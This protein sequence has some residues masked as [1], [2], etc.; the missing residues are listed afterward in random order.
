MKYF[1][2]ILSITLARIASFAQES[3][4]ILESGVSIQ[5]ET[6]QPI[7][8]KHYLEGSTIDLRLKYDVKV[9]NSI[10]IPA[11]T[12]AMGQIDKAQKAKGC[13]KPGL[14]EIK[15]ISVNAVDGQVVQLYSSNVIREGDNKELLAWGLSVGGCFV[16]SPIS[17]F[18]L[19]IKGDEAIIPA[20]ITVNAQTINNETILIE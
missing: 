17:F 1:F 11:G 14:I 18:F 15:A 19:L 20:G 2:L 4:V 3:E 5:L 13:G 6:M 8:S 9:N 7:D 12:L 10:V 16:I